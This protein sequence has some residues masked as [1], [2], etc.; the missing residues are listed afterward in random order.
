MTA[1]IELLGRLFASSFETVWSSAS[2]AGVIA[3]AGMVG[4]IG[5]VTLVAASRVGSIVALA[6]SLSVRT[7]LER[8]IEPADRGE[9][10]SQ[11]DPDAAGRPRPRAP[12]HLLQTA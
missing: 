6:A 9:L 4:A 7:R 12:G 5:L 11:S 3:L 2:P 8:A 1:F 10:L